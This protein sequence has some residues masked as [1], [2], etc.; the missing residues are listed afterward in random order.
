MN[1]TPSN[2]SLERHMEALKGMRDTQQRREYIDAVQRKE[3]KFEAA[4]LK[5]EFAR[6][7]WKEQKK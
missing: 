4:W 2:E 5:D 6:W 7:W 1:T 3:G